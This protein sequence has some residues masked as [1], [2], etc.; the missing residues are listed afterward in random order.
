MPNITVTYTPNLPTEEK[1]ESFALEVH[2]AVA[3]I[4]G[5]GAANFKTYLIP[6][7]RSVIG[8]N[9]ETKAVVHIDF[10]MFGGRS[11][12]VKQ[13]VAST[14]LTLAK[15]WL[16]LQGTVT[17]EISLEVGELDNDNYHKIIINQ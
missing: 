17:T 11:A 13:E 14:I 16:S 7:E 15:K 1:L 3:P 9:D 4:I 6:I 5:S 2:E 8:L 12:V 10:R